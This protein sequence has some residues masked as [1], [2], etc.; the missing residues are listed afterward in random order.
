MRYNSTESRTEF[1]LELQDA[2]ENKSDIEKWQRSFVFDREKKEIRV[3]ED[4]SLK[5]CESIALNFL[6]AVPFIL[7]RDS[8]LMRAKNGKE[9]RLFIDTERFNIT[10]ENIR[11][12]DDDL[13]GRMWDEN[14]YR[15]CLELKDPKAKGSIS[16]TIK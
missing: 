4:Y 8:L 14:L 13:L 11:V 9:L 7:E 1:S 6:S 10:T 2:Y 5:K 16:Y 12:S 3:K 15:I